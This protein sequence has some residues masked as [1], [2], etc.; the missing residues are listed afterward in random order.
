[1]FKITK[2]VSSKHVGYKKAQRINTKNGGVG[3]VEE[4][5]FDQIEDGRSF[6]LQTEHGYKCVAICRPATEEEKTA[7]IQQ[8]AEKAEAEEKQAKQQSARQRLNELASQAKQQGTNADRESI[9][10]PTTKVQV[11]QDSYYNQ[12]FLLGEQ[13]IWY[14]EYEGVYVTV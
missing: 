12:Y 1:M 11:K 3:V 4:V 7:H 10:G 13:N 14:I 5:L 9:Q 8:Q 2:Y 6:G